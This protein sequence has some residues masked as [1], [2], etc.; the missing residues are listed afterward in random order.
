MNYLF[1]PS[2]CSFYDDRIHAEIPDDVVIITED[3]FHEC[4]S[5]R[6]QNKVIVPDSN[7]QPIAV[8]RT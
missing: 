7:G 1:S 6:A 3:R 8:E 5:A 2:T 4:L